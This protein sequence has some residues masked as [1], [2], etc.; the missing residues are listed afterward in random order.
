MLAEASPHMQAM[1]IAALD[2]GMR[3]GEM[4]ALRF[5][6]V[7]MER[8]LIVLRGETT[9]SR[10]SRS[11]PIATARL[12]RV[13]EWLRLD[14]EGQPKPPETALFSNEVG[15]PLRVHHRLY[16]NQTLANLQLAAAKL[17]RGLEF[18]AVAEPS[19]QVTARSA[20]GPYQGGPYRR[21]LS[22]FFQDRS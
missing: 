21:K 3:Q 9:K 2:T 8:G 18:A 14:A 1:I 20:S 12:R 6:D 11:V 17:E 5:S 22:R 4:L 16:D 19:Q 13:L 10:K 15:E 7:D